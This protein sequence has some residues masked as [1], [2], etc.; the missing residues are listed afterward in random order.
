MPNLLAYPTRWS[1]QPGEPDPWNGTS[2]VFTS[3]GD[4]AFDFTQGGQAV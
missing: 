1:L 4:N 2:Y 3:D